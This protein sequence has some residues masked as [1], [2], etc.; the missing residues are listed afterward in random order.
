[1][2]IETCLERCLC[3]SAECRKSDDGSWNCSTKE[4]ECR[5]RCGI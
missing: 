3:D 1:M 2:D 5:E 4:E